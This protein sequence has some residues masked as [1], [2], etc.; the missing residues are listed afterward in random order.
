MRSLALLFLALLAGRSSNSLIVKCPSMAT[1]KTVTAV[2]T[3]TFLSQP[4]QLP[5]GLWIQGVARQ[6]RRVIPI[7]HEL[8]VLL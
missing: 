4:T 2:Y 8:S 1:G 5:E 6:D 7:H 3:G